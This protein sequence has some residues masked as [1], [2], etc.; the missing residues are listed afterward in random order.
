MA[1]VK[2]SGLMKVPCGTKSSSSSA[3]RP[4]K[5]LSSRSDGAHDL[6]QVHRERQPAHIDR[7]S[8]TA[9]KGERRLIRSTSAKALGIDL[10]QSVIPADALREPALQR[11]RAFG[12]HHEPPVVIDPLALA[13]QD[14]GVLEILGIDGQRMLARA[15][16]PSALRR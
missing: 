5:K 2:Y 11:A 15:H 13:E 14:D 10:E 7:G 12:A 16:A 9:A 1:A 8:G 3:S 6:D 4:L